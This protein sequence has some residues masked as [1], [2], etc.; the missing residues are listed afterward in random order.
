M[1]TLCSIAQNL[2]QMFEKFKWRQAF[3][4]KGIMLFVNQ[5][6]HTT[7]TGRVILQ[8]AEEGVKMYA[9]IRTPDDQ[10]LYAAEVNLGPFEFYTLGQ[11]I[12]AGELHSYLFGATNVPEILHKIAPYGT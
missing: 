3:A 11:L 7:L 10:A 4:D 6:A 5:P 8:Q 2:E 12:I 1:D 9:D